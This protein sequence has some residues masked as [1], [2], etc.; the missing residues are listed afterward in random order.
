MNMSPEQIERERQG[1]RRLRTDLGISQCELAHAVGLNQGTISKY[2][3]GFIQ[4]ADVHRDAIVA[5]LV[6]RSQDRFIASSR[7]VDEA[8]TLQQAVGA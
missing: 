8:R 3:Q 4:L 6:Q 7:I 2:E 5:F 1:L